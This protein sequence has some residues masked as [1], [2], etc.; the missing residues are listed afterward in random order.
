MAELLHRASF[1]DL[2]VRQKGRM[3][4][5]WA[6]PF[7]EE[8][9][10][11]FYQEVF[12]HGAFT[13]TIAERGDKVK[14][15]AGHRADRMPLGKASRLEERSKGLWAELF[16]SNTTQG[17]E[18]LQ[19]VADGALDALSIGFRPI[20]HRTRD[21]VLE[22][23]EVRLDEISLVPLPVYDDAEIVAVRSREQVLTTVAARSLITV[24]PNN[25]V[26]SYAEARALYE[27]TTRKS[28]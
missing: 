28:A 17:D 8:A 14:V 9:D 1:A 25:P 7:D 15:L 10:V 18:A 21:G 12:R 13:K 16:I 20:R 2:E 6:V 23:L 3:I 22:R 24:E 5:G 26:L 11:G 27:N 4:V 19:L